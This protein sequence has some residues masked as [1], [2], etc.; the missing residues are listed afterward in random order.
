MCSLLGGAGG[1]EIVMPVH[2]V[3]NRPELLDVLNPITRDPALGGSMLVGGAFWM[4]RAEPGGDL[5]YETDLHC[6]G[7]GRLYRLRYS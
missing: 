6:N 7:W 1:D 2:Y 5:T 4:K 3:Q